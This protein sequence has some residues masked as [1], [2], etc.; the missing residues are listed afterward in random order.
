M[1]CYWLSVPP[2]RSLLFFFFYFFFSTMFMY[3][4]TSL[5]I[6]SFFTILNIWFN[7]VIDVNQ[8]I[9]LGDVLLKKNKPN[10][11]FDILFYYT[12]SFNSSSL[13]NRTIHCSLRLIAIKQWS[14]LQKR[15]KKISWRVQFRNKQ[16]DS[17]ISIINCNWCPVCIIHDVCI[18]KLAEQ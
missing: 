12:S 10:S 4:I 13:F 11:R 3:L 9:Q 2:S 16:I 15:R 7:N 6:S 18:V 17:E 5:I 8:N 14:L 1:K